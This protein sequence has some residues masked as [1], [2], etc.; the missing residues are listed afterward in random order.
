MP[1]D[2]IWYI[3]VDNNVV[4]LL[5][6]FDDFFWHTRHIAKFKLPYCEVSLVVNGVVKSGENAV[7]DPKKLPL[8]CLRRNSVSAVVFAI[9]KSAD[10]NATTTAN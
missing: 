2:F 3:Y 6:I 9:K 7:S 5:L 10:R 4:L 1:L 8:T